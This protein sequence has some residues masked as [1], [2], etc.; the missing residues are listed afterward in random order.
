MF[1]HTYWFSAKHN[2]QGAAESFSTLLE[3]HVTQLTEY[4]LN[5][6]AIGLYLSAKRGYISSHFITTL[7]LLL[8]CRIVILRLLKLNIK[9]RQNIIEFLTANLS[10]IYVLKLKF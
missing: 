2:G 3:P 7:E 10:L 6:Q 5:Y 4:C 9:A 8:A 1:Q